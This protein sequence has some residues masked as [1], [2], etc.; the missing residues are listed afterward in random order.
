M[1]VKNLFLENV[2]KTY[3]GTKI[4]KNL[5]LEIESGKITCVLGPSG[6]GKTTLL[7]ILAGLTSFDG[8]IRNIP[9]KISYI[10]QQERLLPNL[11]VRQ[12]I[13]YVLGKNADYE[14]ID[15]YLEK[16]ELAEKA[17]E[18]PSALSGGQAQRVSIV[19]A[20]VYPSE[21]ILMDEP[22]SSLDTALKI[23]LMKVFCDLWREERRTAIFVTHDAEEA[24]MLSHRAIILNHGEIVADFLNDDNIPRPYG[25]A[26]KYKENILE[27]LLNSN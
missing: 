18:Y 17:N 15:L 4:Y 5:S 2:S 16:A 22:F 14:R 25:A 3:T 1:E 24:Y 21:L 26:S 6:C 12:N 7:N 9:Q 10:F 27:A 8:I 13:A 20:F 11:T 19:R 23:R